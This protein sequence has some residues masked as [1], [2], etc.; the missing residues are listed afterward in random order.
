M[1]NPNIA[2]ATSILGGTAYGSVTSSLAP[3]VTN[4]ASSNTIIK[5]NTLIIINKTGASAA[6]VTAQ[7]QTA[8]GGS[9]T[10]ICINITVPAKS[11]LV[12]ISKDIS[13]YLLEDRRISV[14]CAAS[15]TSL[16]YFVSYET[17]S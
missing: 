5:V 6:D 11:N 14:V 15:A 16:N 8:S 1:S 9:P 2:A 12:L 17:I 4:A 7:I 13:F 10:D 3:V